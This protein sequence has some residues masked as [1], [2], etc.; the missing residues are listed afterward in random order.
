MAIILLSQPDNEYAVNQISALS[1]NK[2]TPQVAYIAS[3]PDPKR[4]FYQQTQAYYAAMDMQL[5]CYL[6]LEDN[7][8]VGMVKQLLEADIIHLSGGDT[9]RFL[10]WLKQRH[11]LPALRAYAIQGGHIVGVSAGAMILSPSIMTAPLC[12]DIN[13]IGLTDDTGLGLAR[14]LYVPH[15][16][17]KNISVDLWDQITQ[18]D[19]NILLA[20]DN[21]AV[22][23]D[24]SQSHYFGEYQWSDSLKE[25]KL[26]G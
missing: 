20:S 14:L 11:L 19:S 23:I 18:I 21:S 15:I 3:S 8:D 12:G 25:G 26:H 7:F 4:Q 10:Y 6:E 1:Q 2:H 24:N 17:L 16:D 22:V 5:N 9:F 13:S